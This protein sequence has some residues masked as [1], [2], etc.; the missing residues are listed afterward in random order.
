VAL[1]YE[2]AAAFEPALAA[3][4]RLADGLPL[5]WARAFAGAD[6]TV[7][8]PDPPS[9]SATPAF[10][11][12]WSEAEFVARARDAQARIADGDTYQV[13]LTF[14]MAAAAP[15]ELAAWY[16]TLRAAQRAPFAACLDLGRHVVISV[17]P[18][19]FFERRGTRV[20]VRPMKGT[21]PRG[22][23]TDEDETRARELTTSAKLR[24][25][26]V[27]IVDLLR[28]DLGRVAVT[29]SVQVPALFTA[30]RYPTVWQLTSTVEADVPAATDLA[31]LLGALF[32]CG[33]VTGAP[34]I[35]T[36]EAIAALE[37][38]PR[39]LYTGAIGLLRPGGDATFSVAIRTVVVDRETGTAT[40]G[41]GAGITADSSP[42]DEY[43][44]SLLKAAFAGE[45]AA[46]APFALLETMRL[47]DGRVVRR[48][49][50]LARLAA[51]ARYFARP[52]DGA[53]V[54]EVLAWAETTH[55]T[56]VWRARLLVDAAGEATVT[57]TPY[58]PDG[59]TWRVA[60]AAGPMDEHDPFLCHKT[61]RRGVYERARRARP[62]VEDVLLWNRR[63]EITE[64]T[65]GNV[66][67]EIDGVRWTPP[68]TSGLLGGTFRAEC[69]EA[70]VIRER[71][72]R[73]ADVARTDRLWLIN[74]V[75]EWIDVE[76]VR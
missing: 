8:P 20:T 10:L 64:G 54:N 19:L 58:A 36:M 12:A 47:E 74:S 53:R 41:V 9:A 68:V 71:V 40:L 31:A 30:E 26:N 63:G 32:P 29:G 69:L 34:K 42:A 61:T 14:P 18:E 60:L 73:R 72:L 65:L 75:R 49:R 27:M 35:R 56:G 70:G 17:S 48:D 25:E 5:A 59:R 24:A 76:L 28:N 39:G 3:P 55:P 57:C 66:V 2:A 67:A 51:S 13:N 46:A 1:A 6:T 15:P 4:V 44:E 23:W 62:H 50:H 45:T 7:A 22:R 38:A 16:A 52:S 37:D 43:R 33:S 11:P 21:L